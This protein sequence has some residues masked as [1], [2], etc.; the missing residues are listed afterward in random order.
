VVSQQLQ[1][2]NTFNDL[3]YDHTTGA[4]QSGGAETLSRIRKVSFP[5]KPSLKAGMKPPTTLYFSNH[6]PMSITTALPINQNSAR[7]LSNAFSKLNVARRPS[8]ATE[9]N[10][11]PASPTL[12]QQQQPPEACSNPC[13]M[14]PKRR[15][16]FSQAPPKVHYFDRQEHEEDWFIFDARL[17]DERSCP[18]KYYCKEEKEKKG[19]K[20]ALKSMLGMQSKKCIREEHDED[21][22]WEEY[23]PS[24]LW[25]H[26]TA[27]VFMF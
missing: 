1:P 8:Q 22:D 6:L 12:A 5:T 11:W 24:N 20:G 25:R 4:N 2:I 13:S 18:W 15:V 14:S 21:E 3:S 10:S 26:D 17:E 19:F 23:Q 16:S 27:A 7:R 9:Q